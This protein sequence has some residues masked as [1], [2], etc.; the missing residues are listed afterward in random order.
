MALRGGE[1]VID[2]FP[3][4]RLGTHFG[5]TFQFFSTLN[6]GKKKKRDFLIFS[7]QVIEGERNANPPPTFMV[8]PVVVVV[9]SG[10]SVDNLVVG[11]VILKAVHAVRRTGSCLLFPRQHIR[12]SITPDKSLISWKL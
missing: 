1:V 8:C 9:V 10:A 12:P 11:Y 4:K 5:L 6:Q 3:P 7:P 2:R